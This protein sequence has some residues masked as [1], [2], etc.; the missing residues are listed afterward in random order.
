MMGSGISS[1]GASVCGRGVLTLGAPLA[2]VTH[3]CDHFWLV[4]PVPELLQGVG[5]S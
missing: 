1:A 5:V 3:L 4:K 2:D